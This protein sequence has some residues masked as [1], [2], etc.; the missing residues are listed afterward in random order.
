MR[1]TR[2]FEASR[3]CGYVLSVGPK[4][5]VM[6]MVID[7]IRFNGY[8]CLRIAEAQSFRYE[9]HATFKEAI[10]WH[11]N[12]KR[13]EGKPVD[14]T[15]LQKLLRSAAAA[16]PLIAVHRG[17]ADPDCRWVGRLILVGRKRLVLL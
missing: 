3:I 9:P 11:R 7:G 2:E 15:N 10:L 4:W 12:D 16:F 5:F 17:M 14:V 6:A 1:V 8:E 13:P